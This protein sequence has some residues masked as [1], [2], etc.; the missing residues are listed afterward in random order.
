LEQQK[1]PYTRLGQRD[2]RTAGA[3][4]V[5]HNPRCKLEE[6]M[7]DRSVSVD[8]ARVPRFLYG[9]AWKEDRTRPLTELALRQGFRGLDTAN[10][11]KHYHEAEVGQAVAVAIAAGLVT[12][13]D[14]FLQ[15]K[16]TFRSG[17][18]HRLPYDPNAPTRTQVEQSFASS[19]EHLGADVIDCYLL[20]GPTKRSGLSAAD[21]EAWRAMEALHQSGQ[22]RLL[23][24]SNV[25]LE[26]LRLL[27]DK[28]HVPPRCVQNRCYAAQGW[29]RAV[30]EFCVANGLIYQGF[31]LLTA[32]RATL[33]RPE[34]AQIARRLG[35]TVT[36][37]VFRFALEVGMIP[38]SG[39]TDP[40]HMR[41]DLDVF[42]FR[43]DADEIEHIERLE[44]S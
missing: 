7:P 35:R 4:K 21:W 31:S 8:G 20:H 44:M 2:V 15:T 18:D 29:D 43:L 37:I 3:M 33:A 14:L 30:R 39:T 28:A 25:T 6:S 38:L 42:D 10:Q 9:T 19:L 1:Q 22:A 41:E 5:S 16:F 32:N 17:Q 40:T 11:R 34:L 36:Q 26:Q 27:C 23:G 13:E 24:V 12:R